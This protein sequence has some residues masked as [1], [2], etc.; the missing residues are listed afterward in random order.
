MSDLMS[1]IVQNRLEEAEHASQ[2]PGRVLREAR[3]IQQI[4]QAELAQRLNLDLKVIDAIER[5]DFAALPP[6]TF[7]KGYLRAYARA[8]GVEPQIVL[9]DYDCLTD[10]PSNEA[11]DIRRYREPEPIHGPSESTLRWVM[12][13]VIVLLVAGVAAYV[14]VRGI[15]PGVSVTSSSDDRTVGAS[16]AATT[17]RLFGQNI[18]AAPEQAAP[19][20]DRKDPV[21]AVAAD[22]P[23]ASP[24]PEFRAMPMPVVLAPVEPPVVAS[25]SPATTATQE[26]ATT[27]PI[28]A[29]PLTLASASNPETSAAIAAPREAQTADASGLA[30]SIPESLVAGVDV[31]AE[32]VAGERVAA[33]MGELAFSEDCWTSVQAG[34]GER[35]VYRVVKAGSSV[36]LAGVAPFNVTLGNAQAVQVSFAGESV[37]I[38]PY[39]RGNIA[40]FTLPLTPR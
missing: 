14:A 18:G 29:S 25:P 34:D 2:G 21:A 17:P 1:E 9:D 40:R 38:A 27:A 19:A 22:S 12:L 37:D 4:D 24:G 11:I 16:S 35:L 13:A 30:A 8:V 10:K 32:A 33:A 28:W 20:I 39:T 26:P 5:G 6:P 7:I 31:D 3:K 15:V 23:D 36:S